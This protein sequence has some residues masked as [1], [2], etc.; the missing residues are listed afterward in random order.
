MYI[1]IWSSKIIRHVQKQYGGSWN[2]VRLN[3]VRDY[4]IQ[5]FKYFSEKFLKDF[6]KLHISIL[7]PFF[8]I[9]III[10]CH[11]KK[12]QIHA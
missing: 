4:R 1:I 7:K 11:H 2:G 8:I 12:E 6:S 9:I 3:G 5:K 10:Y